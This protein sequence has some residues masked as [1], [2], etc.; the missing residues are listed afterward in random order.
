MHVRCVPKLRAP[1]AV[2]PRRYREKGP[3]RLD[4]TRSRQHD[5]LPEGGAG[6]EQA[7][8]TDRARDI[9]EL[10]RMTSNRS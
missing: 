9:S 3:C 2:M 10:L 6:R 8:D 4:L 7:K 5:M 1:D